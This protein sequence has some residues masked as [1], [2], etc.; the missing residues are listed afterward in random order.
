M[1]DFLGLGG[2]DQE[3]HTG[4]EPESAYADG[5]EVEHTH[6][7]GEG[8]VGAGPIPAVAPPP[9]TGGGGGGGG[10]SPSDQAYGTKEHGD[11]LAKVQG[12]AMEELLPALAKLPPATLA[13]TAAASGVGG[14]RLVLAIQVVRA[15][16]RGQGYEAFTKAHPEI[17]ELPPD[18]QE[19]IEA[20][21]TKTDTSLPADVH[22][23]PIDA[24][25]SNGTFCGITIKDA[26]PVLL[27]RLGIAERHLEAELGL[28]GEA[29]RKELKLSSTVSV[30]R[31]DAFHLF[32]LAIDFNYDSDPYVG[33]QGDAKDHPEELKGDIEALAVIWRACWLTGIGDGYSPKESDEIGKKKDSTDEL[34]EHLHAADQAIEAYLGAR[35]D[36]AKIAAW[37]AAGNLARAVPTPKGKKGAAADLKR[38]ALAGADAAAW[39]A[40]AQDDFRI[41]HGPTAKHSNWWRTG[42]GPRTDLGILDLD[43]RLVMALREVANLGWGASDFGGETNGDMMHFDCRRDYSAEAIRAEKK[44]KKEGGGGG[45]A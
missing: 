3:R 34:W 25:G 44:R 22:G 12:L 45:S 27:A 26:H 9:A 14:P 33:G 18:Q 32:G 35:D 29:L 43:K 2:D 37:I 23:L 36:P 42:K 4:H 39:Q 1:F 38:E 16:M 7:G 20:Y 6:G 30:R 19:A 21:L 11:Q 41:T 10:P 31:N 5:G 15:K 24:P 17:A 13:D 8:L 40:Q 28:T